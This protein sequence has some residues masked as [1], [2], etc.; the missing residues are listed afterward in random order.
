MPPP[1]PLGAHGFGEEVAKPQAPSLPFPFY[2]RTP[3]PPLA[4]SRLLVNE[5]QRTKWVA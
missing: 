4:P 5:P 2:P 1:L 3:P